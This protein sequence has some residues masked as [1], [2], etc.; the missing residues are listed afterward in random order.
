MTFLA[1]IGARITLPD[2]FIF[3]LERNEIRADTSFRRIIEPLKDEIASPKSRRFPFCTFCAAKPEALDS[4][5][6]RKTISPRLRANC[7][8]PASALALESKTKIKKRRC[9]I[10]LLSTLPPSDGTLAMT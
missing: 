8:A 10:A 4:A 1:V 6:S 5:D 3:T 9:C 2:Q 7:Y